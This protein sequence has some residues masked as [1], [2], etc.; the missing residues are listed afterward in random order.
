MSRILFQ[1]CLFI[2]TF[3]L[4]FSQFKKDLPNMNAFPQLDLGNSSLSTLFSPSR[5]QMNHGINFSVSNIGGKT[6]NTGSYTNSLSYFL[7]PNLMLRSNFTLF[8]MPENLGQQGE[9]GYDVS[10]LYKP[11]RNSMIQFSFQKFPFTNNKSFSPFSL[12]QIN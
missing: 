10:L 6:F 2:F 4:V 9:L 12:N 7:K 8:Q 3:S 5:L 11:S 1:I